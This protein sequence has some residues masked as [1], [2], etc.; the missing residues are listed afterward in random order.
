[1]EPRG[2]EPRT[3]PAKT[4]SELVFMFD[5]VVTPCFGVVRICV[6]VLRD[7]TVL[8]RSK[9]RSQSRKNRPTKS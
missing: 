7:A 2:F 3:D 6:R 9:I 5:G 8:G 1:V 4:A